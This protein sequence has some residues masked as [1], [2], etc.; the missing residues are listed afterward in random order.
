MIELNNYEKAV[1]VTGDGD[2]ACLVEYLKRA[3]KLD[4]VLS[5]NRK[6][7][8]SLLK[9]AFHRITFLEDLK[10]KLEFREEEK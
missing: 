10:G 9:Q 1:L 5:P 4:I 6:F 8:S 3:D 7:C 2:F